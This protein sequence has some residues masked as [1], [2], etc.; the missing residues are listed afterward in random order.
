VLKLLQ[1]YKYQGDLRYIG[2]AVNVSVDFEESAL[3]SNCIDHMK[4]AFEVAH[5]TQ[6]T[7]RLSTNIEIMNLRI[8]AEETRTD[9]GL[10]RLRKAT[11]SSPPPSAAVAQNQFVYQTQQYQSMIW[12]REKL[13]WGHVLHGPCIIIEMDSTT[14][15]LPGYQ[16]EI[17]E[18][19]NILI[20][21]HSERRT[22]EE[23]AED[24]AFEIS[25]VSVDIFENALRNARA[26][27]DSLMTHATM[28]PAIREQQD[29][30]NVIA[31]PE[32]KMLVGQ[33]GSFIGQF[34]KM[35]TGSVD[36]GDIFIANDPYSIGGSV[37]HLN[38]WLIFMPVFVDNKLS[39]G[40]RPQ[41]C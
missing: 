33:F 8:I 10:Q 30:F 38:D 22:A 18:F 31:N 41:Y 34:Y 36:P 37:S 3:S 15:V 24:Q 23:H 32:G 9:L 7:F 12:E 25:P 4:E 26:E 27:M 28:S 13:L 16:A 19:G 29:E 5:E 17:D 11:E 39:K 35:W 21:E 1:T 14:V 40:N 6:Y 2:Q 20:T